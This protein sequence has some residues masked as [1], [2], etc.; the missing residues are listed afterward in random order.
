ME[1]NKFL[2]LDGILGRRSFIVNYFIVSIIM[3]LVFATPFFLYIFMIN[4][5]I[6]SNLNSSHSV[7]WIALGEIVSTVLLFPSIVRRIRDIMHEE[8]ENNVY[9]YASLY[10]IAVILSLLPTLSNIFPIFGTIM[11]IA[12]ACINGKTGEQPKSEIIKFNWGAFW[13]TWIW[14]I[15]NK[16]PIALLMIPLMF[17]T[18]GLPFAIICGLKGNEWAY[19]NRKYESVEKFHSSQKL[20]AIIWTI[21]YPLAALIIFIGSITAIGILANRYVSTH[22]QVKTNIQSAVQNYEKYAI[23]S[24]FSE[25]KKEGDEY[26][27]Y[28]NPKIWSKMSNSSKMSIFNTAQ[29]YVQNQN[30][31]ESKKENDIKVLNKI[32]I[33]S[34]FNNE[35]LGEFIFDEQ[36]FKTISEDKNNNLKKAVKVYKSIKEGYKFNNHPSLP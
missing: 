11:I 1:N 18:A 17:T 7:L 3:N 32:K 12:L 21:I 20:Q 22:P 23:D 36:I 2:S 30:K 8:N 14:G 24:Y 15:I 25:V 9:L 13:G 5:G 27:F 26:H 31:K 35:L 33:Y 6:L 4:P 29:E 28:M 34:S 16:T 19:Q 10:P